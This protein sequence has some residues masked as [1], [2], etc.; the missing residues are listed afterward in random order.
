MKNL[1]VSKRAADLSLAA[2]SFF[3]GVT[4]V[5]VKDD[6]SKVSAPCHSFQPIF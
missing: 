3:R 6:V 5:I 1:S 2:A 4:F